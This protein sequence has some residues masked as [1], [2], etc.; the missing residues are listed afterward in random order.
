MT[1]TPTPET[2]TQKLQADYSWLTHH[3]FMLLVVG[4]LVV[5]SVYGVESI[6]ARHDH[7]AALEK[8][9]LAQTLIQ[10]NQQFQ[11]QTQA[12][13]N[14]LAQQNVALQAEVGTLASAITA[15][16]AQ[17]RTQQ[18]Q[19]PTLTPDQ[20]S[21]EWQ[22]DIKNAG[23]VKPLPAGGY[24]VD[25]TGAVATVQLL[26]SEA[27]LEVDKADLQKQNSNLQV[28]FTNEVA[29]YEAE[30]KAHDSDNAANKATIS[31]KDAEIKDVKA[32]CRKS[33]LKW[34]GIG[35]LIG[36]FGGHAAGV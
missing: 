35:I 3:I 13:I 6:V 29:I 21:V 30:K 25:Q 27:T 19:I 9:A 34:L 7:A 36:I 33:K 1:A 8:Q 23:N 20:L 15:R 32:Q 4:V 26:E 17:L 22:K 14:S 28:Q 11:Q 12:T 10:Q 2:I 5:S 31:A 18:A 16:D 24:S